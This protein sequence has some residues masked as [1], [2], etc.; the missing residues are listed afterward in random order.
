MVLNKQVFPHTDGRNGKGY[1]CP[2][3]LFGNKRKASKIYT[4]DSTNQLLGI[5]PKDNTGQV[6]NGV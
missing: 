5:Y 3:K 2:R 1:N 6:E 4:F